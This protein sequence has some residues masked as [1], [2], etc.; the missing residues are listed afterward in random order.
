MLRK[1]TALLQTSG[2]LRRGSG[3]LSGVVALALSLLCVL[4]VLA[5]HFPQYLT[6]PELRVRY[7]VE[8]L[9]HVLSAALLIAGGLSL[10]NIALGRT[11][12]LNGA[13]FLLVLL[14]IAM[15]GSR[16]PVGDF[17]VGTPYLGLDW[18]ILDLLGSA[19]V[20]VLIEKLFPLY[21]GQPVFRKDWQTD[22]TYF[23]VNHLLV[24]VLLLIVNFMVH[25]LFGWAAYAP[26]QQ[27][28]QS[29]PLVAE[30]LLLLLLADL[31]QYWLHRAYHE[32]PLL[33]RFHSIHHSAQVL[34]WMAGSRLHV[35]EV[36]ATRIAVLGPIYMLGF[37]KQALDVYIVIVGFHAVLNHSN[38]RLPWGPLRYILVTPDFHHWHHSSERIALDRNYAAHF[39]F[40]DRLF[41]TAIR[42]AGQY[43]EH[44]GVVGDGVPEGFV[45]QQLQPFVWKGESAART[46]R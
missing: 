34:D 10:G 35:L 14:A 36:L 24:G 27:K 46:P 4:A 5:F 9:R 38:V 15:G 8:G 44:Y 29:L 2:E 33:W 32:V 16:V 31:I 20:F 23:L 7:P 39:P 19:L 30:V 41:G 17:P 40:L 25:R 26:L 13:A 28:I 42:N 22:S 12:W 11:R 21:R 43:P 45:R 18:F 37:S 6:T 1:I 3:Q